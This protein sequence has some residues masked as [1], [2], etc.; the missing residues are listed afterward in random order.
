MKKLLTTGALLL[1]CA[2]AHASPISWGFSYRGFFDREANQFIADETI[3]GAFTGDDLNS[4]GLLELR[5]LQSLVIGELDYIACAPGS[6]AYYQCG[7]TAFSFSADAGL[8]FAVGSYGADPEG[9]VGGG[10]LITT[11]EQ[12]YD[13]DYYP[14]SMRERHLMWTAD[15]QL[16]M[17]STSMATVSDV[18]EPATLLMFASGLAAIGWGARR[19]R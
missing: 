17:R 16:T 19:R 10:R 11:G 12:Q 8:N 3:H 2:S 1:C 14:N 6:N 4:N 5:E 15:T 18:P 13:Y 7:A 9:W